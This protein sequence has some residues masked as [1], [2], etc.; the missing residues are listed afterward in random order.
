[1]ELYVLGMMASIMM[2]ILS[3]RKLRKTLHTLAVQ[4]LISIIFAGDPFFECICIPCTAITCTWQGY[5]TVKVQGSST[6]E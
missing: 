6:N 5:T 3:P 2:N 4:L 1:M